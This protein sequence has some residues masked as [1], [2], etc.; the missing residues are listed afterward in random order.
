MIPRSAAS[1]AGAPA[2]AAL[3]L[4]CAPTERAAP[5]S[6]SADR[7]P[8][9][10]AAAPLPA[11]AHPPAP[12]SAQG[13]APMA[14]LTCAAA[15]TAIETHKLLGWTGLPADCTPDELFGIPFDE[16]TW[17]LHPLGS[18]RAPSRA[19]L[20]ELPGYHRPLARVRGRH[21]VMFDAM[22]P[23]LSTDWPTLAA[24]LG[25]PDALLDFVF[26]DVP[27]PR[28]EHVYAARGI[29]VFV[30]PESQRILYVALYPP[31]T[32]DSYARTLRPNLEKK[33]R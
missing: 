2:L 32:A 28:G 27:M 8:G 26:G 18:T 31:T 20:L 33:R 24:D 19:R 9:S 25:S 22:N 23:V 17:G 7:S 5:T 3:L 16:A 4:A 14:P 10:R 15:R 6:S 11:A 30:S 13:T 21:V 12:D 29:T 1:F